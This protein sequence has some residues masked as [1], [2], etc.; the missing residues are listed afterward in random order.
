MCNFC[1]ESNYGYRFYLN[2]FY[3][4]IWNQYKLTRASLKC[5]NAVFPGFWFFNINHTHLLTVWRLKG[6]YGETR[7]QVSAVAWPGSLDKNDE[8]VLFRKFS[9]HLRINPGIITSPTLSRTVARLISL[10]QRS[11]AIT[12]RWSRVGGRPAHF[13]YG[14]A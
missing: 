6:R 3:F 4:T 9:A 10:G 8:P 13:S 14:L 2:C 5:L 7:W 1:R 11:R 12:R